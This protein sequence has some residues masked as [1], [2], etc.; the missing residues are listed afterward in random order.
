MNKLIQTN[1]VK[2][3]NEVSYYL[4]ENEEIT[5]FT[6]N[7]E[8]TVSTDSGIQLYSDYEGLCNEWLNTDIHE[9][10]KDYRNPFNIEQMEYD[11]QSYYDYK[12][13]VW[14]DLY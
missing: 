9:S 13:G 6:E 1:T 4:L 12:K 3:I 5:F 10:D 11:K 8:I 2:Y 14:F 7:E